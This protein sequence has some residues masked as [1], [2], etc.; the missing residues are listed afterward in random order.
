MH[1]APEP[2]AG[3]AKQSVRGRPDHGRQ[4]RSHNG[5]GGTF[6]SVD[7]SFKT[8]WVPQTNWLRYRTDLT[9]G[10]GTS[11]TVDP[12]FKTGCVQQNNWLR[13]SP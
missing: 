3:R 13:I 7:P 1:T 5:P 8:G 12:S 6:Y 11:R 10:P 2:G 9:N 4:G